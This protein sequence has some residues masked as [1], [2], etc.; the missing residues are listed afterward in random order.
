VPLRELVGLLD[1]SALVV[2]LDTAPLHMAVALDRPVIG[3]MGYNN[4]KRVGPWRR[5]HD[6][7]VDAYGD[8]GED[9]PITIAHRRGRTRRIGV[10][11][12]LKKVEVWEERYR[13]AA[14]GRA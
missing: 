3:L 13:S 4:P 7:V 1:A 11:D 5:F 9:Y 12:V 8:P 6:L 10:A 14:R 2:S